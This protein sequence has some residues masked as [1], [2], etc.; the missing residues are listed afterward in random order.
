MIEFAI[1]VAVGVVFSVSI[2]AAWAKWARRVLIKMTRLEGMP[3]WQKL[4]KLNASVC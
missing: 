4:R 1:G 3:R 2:K